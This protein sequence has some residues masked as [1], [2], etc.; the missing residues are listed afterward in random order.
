LKS[1]KENLSLHNGVSIPKIGFGTWMMFEGKTTVD[2]V[3][4]ALSTGYRHVD[5]AALYDNEISVGKAIRTSGIPRK[6]VFVTSKLEAHV[7]NASLAQE[8]LEETMRKLDLAYL[9][10]YLIHAPA[11]WGDKHSRYY[12]ENV[13]VYRVLEHYYDTGKLRAIGVSN[14]EIADLE[15]IMKHCDIV[16]HVNQIKL[17]PGLPQTQL[18]NFCKAHDI[19][20]EAYSPLGQ[21]SLLT[22]PIIKRLSEK[23]DVTPAQLCIRYCLEKGTIPLPKTQNEKRMVENASMAFRIEEKDM[24]TLDTLSV[25]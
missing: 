10:L 1:L 14:F 24:K 15:N 5:T 8:A 21:G 3:K 22:D 11:P 4:K 18:V 12:R 17:H 20:V 23:Y 7:K 16:P 25:T 19:V 13:D 9:D 2:V 6:Q